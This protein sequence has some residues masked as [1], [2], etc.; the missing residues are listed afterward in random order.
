[1]I[2]FTAL[3]VSPWSEK[4]RWALLHHHIAFHEESYTPGLSEPLLRLRLRKF[5]GKVTVPVLYDGQR[6]YTD[7]F[8]IARFAEHHATAAGK[9]LLPDSKLPEIQEWNRRSEAALAAGRQLFMVEVLKNPELTKGLIPPQVPEAL[10]P[11]LMPVLKLGNQMFARKYRLA[12]SPESCRAEM[13]EALTG[14]EQALGGRDYLLGDFSYA[15]ITMAVVLQALQPVEPRY[16][17]QPMVRGSTG[18]VDPELR[19][20]FKGLIDWRDRLYAKHRP[21]R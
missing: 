14:L 21:V 7:S 8:E 3:A 13:T 12:K 16:G 10:R 4:A 2:R 5:N 6:Y 17:I 15:D 1:M 19:D 18:S 9:P 20:R 11:A